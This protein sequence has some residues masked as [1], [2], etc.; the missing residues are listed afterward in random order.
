MADLQ[1]ISNEQAQTWLSGLR[2]GDEQA[3]EHLFHHYYRYLV[4]TAYNLL[5]DDQ[6]AKDLV[7]DV[8][9]HLWTKR[10]ELQVDRSLK[11]YLRRSVVNR[12][13]DELRRSKRIQWQ[14]DWQDDTISSSGLEAEEELAVADLQL[15]VNRAIDRLPKRCKTIFS[16]SRFEHFSNQEIA[17]QLDI[18]IKTVENQMTK[19]LKVIRSAVERYQSA[20]W[21]IY[22]AV[23]IGA[24]AI[25]IV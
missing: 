17:D 20:F 14:G 25:S 21:L 1:D 22:W 8:F 19:A 2:A 6:R 9:F 5:Q 24:K 10:T 12:S 15:V 18:S 23:E 7:Q 3:L 13:I 4:V 16:L 11:A